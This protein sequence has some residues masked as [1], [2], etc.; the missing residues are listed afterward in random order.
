MFISSVPYHS[1]HFQQNFRSQAGPSTQD[2]DAAARFFSPNH[3]A[4]QLAGPSAYDLSALHR[5][6]PHAEAQHQQQGPLAGWAA[7]FLQQQPIQS[8]Q[9]ANAS[10]DQLQRDVMSPN[11]AQ[12]GANVQPTG[13]WTSGHLSPTYI[14]T[15][16]N[17]D[18]RYDALE[19][20][21]Y[22][23]SDAP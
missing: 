11:F 21:S 8:P 7:D 23:T 20:S 14:S 1:A 4:P 12:L 17:N 15:Y 18:S 10:V 6:L 22:G 13:M 16:L 5:S 19:P 3:A 9:A 2:I